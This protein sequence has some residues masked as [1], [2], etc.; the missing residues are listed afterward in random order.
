MLLLLIVLSAGYYSLIP[1][2]LVAHPALWIVNSGFWAASLSHKSTL[3]FLDSGDCYPYFG[4]WLRIL[5]TPHSEF[6][7]L[8]QL[9]GFW[10]RIMDC[11]L[12]SS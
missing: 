12:L 9:S 11:G 2:S 10:L 6:W 3:R 5:A 8:L 1:T 7:R 4:F